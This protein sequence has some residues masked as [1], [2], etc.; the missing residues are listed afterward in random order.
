[1]F[2]YIRKYCYQILMR[3]VAKSSRGVTPNHHEE[4]HQIIM[5]SDTKSSRGVT[6]NHHGERCQISASINIDKGKGF[7]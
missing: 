5:G 1:M 3:S 4:R 6:P 7:F 2:S